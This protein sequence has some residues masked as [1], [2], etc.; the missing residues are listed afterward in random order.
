MEEYS[1]PLE[2]RRGYNLLQAFPA[3]QPAWQGKERASGWCKGLDG[4]W[5]GQPA[6]P[7]PRLREGGR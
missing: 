2:T 1:T 5:P 3:Q 4:S 6:H 7:S